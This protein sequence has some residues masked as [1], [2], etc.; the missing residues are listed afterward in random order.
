MDTVT[1]GLLKLK[2]PE[3]EGAAPKM[4]IDKLWICKNLI[5]L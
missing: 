5:D 3:V 4:C 2:G 1:F